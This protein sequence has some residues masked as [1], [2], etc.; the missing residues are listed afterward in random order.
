MYLCYRNYFGTQGEDLS[1]VNM[2]YPA[3]VPAPGS[4]CYRH[5]K[6]G[7]SDAILI[8]CDSVVSTT[9]HFMLNLALLFVLMFFS[10]MFSIMITSL[11]KE[12][13]GLCVFVCFFAH[14]N[15]CPFSLRLGVRGWLRPA[16]VVLP[17]LLY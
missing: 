2:L 17:G 1:T 5:F 15:Y 13:A 7:G 10:V 14:V 3:S 11:E 16:I 4:L 6:G 12:I 9:G 8:L